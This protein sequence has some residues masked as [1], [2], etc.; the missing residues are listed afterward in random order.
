MILDCVPIGARYIDERA[1]ENMIYIYLIM[2]GGAGV[3]GKYCSCG[4]PYQCENQREE[5]RVNP[6]RVVEQ[7][8]LLAWF[9]CGNI[10]I[11]E[12]L[13]TELLRSRLCG[14]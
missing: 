12:K 5:K 14:Q 9:I 3:F 7:H 10:L 11:Y 6:P 1:V 8:F 13:K 4:T 2:A